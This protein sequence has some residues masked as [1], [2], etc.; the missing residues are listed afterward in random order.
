MADNEGRF[1]LEHSGFDEAF[2]RF[3]LHAMPAAL[4]KGLFQAGA[5]WLR[6]A[7][8]VPPR[9][10]HLTGALWR[11]QEIQTPD[12]EKSDEIAVVAGFNIV[13]AAYQHEGIREDGTHQVQEYTMD[14]SGPKFLEAKAAM[15]GSNY[16]SIVVDW[17]SREAMK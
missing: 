16:L 4:K 17:V 10:P 3:A 5:Q 7:I 2:V 12:L 9:A 13:Y 1:V 14:G 6:D 8:E 15:F 11:S